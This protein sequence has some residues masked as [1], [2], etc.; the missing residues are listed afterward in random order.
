M[1]NVG[2]ETQRRVSPPAVMH[3]ETEFTSW[4]QP[5]WFSWDQWS[6]EQ[7]FCRFVAMLQRMLQP[8]VVVETG[9]GVGRLTSH[10]DLASCTYFGFE[11]DPK[12]R[13][14]PAGPQETPTV[15][16][17]ASADL[18]ILDSTPS[19]RRQEID[20]WSAFGKPGSV[21]V[22]HDC[23]NGHPAKATTHH[24]LRRAVEDTGCPGVFLANPRGG[25]FGWHP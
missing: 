23:G 20:M 14:P 13:Q 17:M 11:S 10:L 3:D 21:C 25:W 15:D 16:D 19:Y 2:G 24:D 4:A 12:W 8:A 9:V 7:D 22:V 6:P 5:G 18:V 1:G